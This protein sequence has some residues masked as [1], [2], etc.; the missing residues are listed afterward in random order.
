LRQ[1]EEDLGNALEDAKENAEDQDGEDQEE[2]RL[3]FINLIF[4]KINATEYIWLIN[5]I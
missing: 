5:S 4:R 2:D 1:E 3:I